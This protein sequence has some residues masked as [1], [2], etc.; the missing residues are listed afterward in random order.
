MEGVIVSKPN[1]SII[2]KSEQVSL[3]GEIKSLFELGYENYLLP[4]FPKDELLPLSLFLDRIT[5]Y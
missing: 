5:F 1:P 2:S 4:S 3:Q